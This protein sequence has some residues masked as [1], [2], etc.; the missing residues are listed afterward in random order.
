MTA[1]KPFQLVALLCLL[2][3]IIWVIVSVVDKNL[4]NIYWAIGLGALAVVFWLIYVYTTR[5]NKPS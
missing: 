3:A 2:A 1:L 5:V 4:G